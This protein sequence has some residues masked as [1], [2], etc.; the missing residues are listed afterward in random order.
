MLV[1]AALGWS[2]QV[3]ARFTNVCTFRAACAHPEA[4]ERL[5]DR[6]F[7]RLACRDVG[8]AIA[9]RS[10]FGLRHPASVKRIR[11][12]WIAREDLVV[13]GNCGVELA[14]FQVGEAAAVNRVQG[15]WGEA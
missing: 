14:Q 12:R 13:I 1:L 3:L 15:V 2:G 8:L 6:G 4:G 7:D 5:G 9:G 10:L 11:A